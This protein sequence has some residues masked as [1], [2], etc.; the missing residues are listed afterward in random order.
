MQNRNH[1]IPQTLAVL[2]LSVGLF[3]A[4]PADAR[5]VDDCALATSSKER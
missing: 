3:A 1:A 5:T 2:A 4:A